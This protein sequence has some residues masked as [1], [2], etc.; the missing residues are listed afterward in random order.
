MTISPRQA[1]A[2]LWLAACGSSA[3]APAGAPPAAPSSTAARAPATCADAVANMIQISGR[4][5]AD[6]VAPD[7][8]EAWVERMAA[9]TRASCD[10]DRWPPDLLQCLSDAADRVALDACAARLSP[11]ATA[12]FQRRMHPILAELVDEIA[13]TRAAPPEREL[14]T[15]GPIKVGLFAALSGADAG[16]SIERGV[17]LA[18][19]QRNA[20]GGVRGRPIELVTADTRSARDRVSDVVTGL[21]TDDT[22]VALLADVS[23]PAALAGA[24]VAQQY[25]VPMIAPAAT[26]A[27]FTQVGDMIFR[28]TFADDFQGE[29]AATFARTRLGAARAALLVPAANPYAQ[30]LAAGFR[31][32][33]VAQGGALATEQTYVDG[34]SDTSLVFAAIRDSRADVVYLPGHYRDAAALVAKAR[35][36]RVKAPFL[37]GDA[38]DSTELTRLGGKA[39]EGAYYTNHFAAD[40]PRAEV[41]AFVK[42]YRAAHKAAPDAL[43]ALAYDAAQMLFAAMDRASAL[44]G[45]TLAAA[46]AA[47]R[48]F[49]GVTGTLSIDAARNARK[50]AVVVHIKR[51]AP[52]FAASIPPT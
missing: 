3:A 7:R 43:A 27:G 47:T 25:G 31:D 5:A 2:I 1:L 14:P 24:R 45:A 40:E 52:R 42:R 8:R 28:A 34:D 21:V 49:P 29:A 17:R 26:G 16:T 15:E 30:A 48:D 6:G 10:E 11:E 51:G 23:T 4:R 32:A 46:I 22:V 19:E 38:W 18:V 12:A 33:F 50:P 13:E 35:K 41:T 36:A 9:A 20:A 44:D 39:I 37:G